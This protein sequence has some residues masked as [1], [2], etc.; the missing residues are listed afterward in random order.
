M[1]SP[2]RGFKFSNLGSPCVVAHG[3][4]PSPLRGLLSWNCYTSQGII[5]TAKMHQ[6]ETLEDETSM[7]RWQCSH[8]PL[9]SRSL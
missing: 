4:M 3:C 1:V 9:C 7:T 6:Y 5:M 8:Q 2:L